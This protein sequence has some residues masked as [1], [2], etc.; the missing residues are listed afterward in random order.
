M[1]LSGLNV[2][3]SPVD[4]RAPKLDLEKSQW[5]VT[6]PSGFQVF[7]SLVGVRAPKLD[8][9][10]SQWEVTTPSGSPSVHVTYGS[11]SSQAG[12]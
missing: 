7:V 2:F 3:T 12:P 11:T 5:E 8:P 10:K 6:T 1:A 9:K 4:M